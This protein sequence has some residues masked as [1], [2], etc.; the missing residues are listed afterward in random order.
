MYSFTVN[1]EGKWPSINDLRNN[2]WSGNQGLKKKWRTKLGWLIIEQKPKK[3]SKY[4][5][6][7]RYSSRLDPDNVVLKF[8][9][10][11]LK[12]TGVIIDDNKKYFRGYSILPDESLNNNQYII[13][14]IEV[15]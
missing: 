5:V 4:Q 13:K 1:Y 11:A 10:D 2:Q 8:F 6:Q 9:V 14:V 12:D 3:L 15:E 7:V